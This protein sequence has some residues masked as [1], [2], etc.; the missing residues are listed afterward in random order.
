M[1]S[2]KEKTYD[3]FI[4][5]ASEDKEKMAIPLYCHL[6]HEGYRVWLDKFE[7]KL[8]T[9]LEEAINDGI[10]Q[11]RMGIA[12]I[13]DSYLHEM[14]HW[15]KE[16]LKLMSQLLDKRLLIPILYKM[17][18]EEAVNILPE[19]KEYRFFEL[20]KGIDE[21]VGEISRVLGLARVKP[22]NNQQDDIYLM[23]RNL[24][25][26]NDLLEELCYEISREDTFRV[27]T[28]DYLIEEMD[29]NIS[30]ALED[31]ATICP[32]DHIKTFYNAGLLLGAKGM[33]S[34]QVFR[35]LFKRGLSFQNVIEALAYIPNQTSKFLN[36]KIL[37][38]LE[39]DM[40]KVSIW[41]WL[42]LAKKDS[43]REFLLGPE[44]R[45]FYE[46]VHYF[47]REVLGSKDYKNHLY[48]LL[49]LKDKTKN[50][51]AIHDLER[52]IRKWEEREDYRIEYTLSGGYEVHDYVNW[53]D[54]IK[55]QMKNKK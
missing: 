45:T 33:V 50:E 22:V 40:S 18:K 19:L 38:T 32:R 49:D 16:E 46:L 25:R 29:E 28:A 26:D 9:K 13:S 54:V 1:N 12:L 34:D 31:L 14:K 44:I 42:N 55:A 17:K 5:H 37:R 27:A 4:S 52:T 36:R 7:I 39:E 47:E 41:E 23:Y 51:D 53:M 8:G 20:S 30:D 35:I 24:C 10:D 3:V 15:T 48:F 21:V 43:F 2:T 6:S 11:S